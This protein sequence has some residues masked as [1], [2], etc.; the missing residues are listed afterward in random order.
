MELGDGVGMVVGGPS[1]SI[2]VKYGKLKMK[3]KPGAGVSLFRVTERFLRQL[4]REGSYATATQPLSAEQR[5]MQ[6]SALAMLE[7]VSMSSPL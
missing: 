4:A 7:R 5:S 6:A 3:S 2:S 1:C